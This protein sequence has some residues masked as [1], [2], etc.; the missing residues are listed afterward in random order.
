MKEK[1]FSWALNIPTESPP[2]TKTGKKIVSHFFFKAYE[3]T[4]IPA[5]HLQVVSRPL[6]LGRSPAGPQGIYADHKSRARSPSQIQVL[7]FFSTSCKKK[8]N[9]YIKSV[10]TY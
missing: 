9:I 2:E 10:P 4:A 8:K 3:I 7:G 6:S 5:K 1:I